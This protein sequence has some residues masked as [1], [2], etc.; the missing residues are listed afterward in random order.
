M[1]TIFLLSMVAMLATSCKKDTENLQPQA[2][3]G[4]SVES[5]NSFVFGKTIVKCATGDCA[6]FYKIENGAL[7]PDITV[8]ND[9]T[10]PIPF[11]KT[12]LSN[13]KYLIAKELEATMPDYMRSRPNQDFGCPN[14]Y[15]QGLYRVESI[16]NG[17]VTYWHL[18]TNISALPAEV[19]PWAQRLESVLAQFP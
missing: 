11:S 5:T 2:L 6:E 18:D 12:A 16:N 1:K 14:C 8:H 10:E 17:V 3:A 19:Q 15:D 13:E 7:Y 9:G 4:E